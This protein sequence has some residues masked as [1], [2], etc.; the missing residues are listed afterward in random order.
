MD[1]WDI[2]W[3]I[4]I[5][6]FWILPL[7]T[8]IFESSMDYMSA[9]FNIFIMSILGYSF[10]I[11]SV[12]LFFTWFD[13]QEKSTKIAEYEH[14]EKKVSKQKSEISN[15]KDEIESYE[16]IIYN[17]LDTIEEYENQVYGNSKDNPLVHVTPHGKKYHWSFCEKLDNNS[18]RT[19]LFEA[20]NVGY[21]PCISCMED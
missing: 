14:S 20:Q 18:I 13:S 7:L 3:S 5:N 8:I 9:D 12:T 10:I 2:F 16:T 15:L 1:G 21:T 19:T 11:V 6:A 4:I 17:L